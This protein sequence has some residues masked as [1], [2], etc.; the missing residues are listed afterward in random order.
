LI[1]LRNW[2]SLGAVPMVMVFGYG[3]NLDGNQGKID[4]KRFNI[5]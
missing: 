3:Y 4:E 5:E 1:F 2:V